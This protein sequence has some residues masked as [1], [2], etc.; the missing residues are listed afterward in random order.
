MA[1]RMTSKAEATAMKEQINTVV[2]ALERRGL[3]RGQI[4]CCMAGIGLGL[5]QAHLGHAKAMRVIKAVT[6]ALE[7][8][9]IDKDFGLEPIE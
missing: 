7:H 5:A 3:G 9:A 8:D 4:G 6:L 1:E 2:D